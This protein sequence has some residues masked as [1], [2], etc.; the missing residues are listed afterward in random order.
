[1]T[2][3]ERT[4]GDLTIAVVDSHTGGEPTRVIVGGFPELDGTALA[5]KRD[6]L[7][8]N[9]L[10][11]ARLIVDEPRGNEAMVAALLV[12]PQDPRCTAGVIF[13]DRSA[14]LG[15]CGHGT[16]GLVE[17]LRWLGDVETGEVMIETPVG[18]ITA[19]INP[20]GTI[21]IANVPS[22]RIADAITV[23]VP[24]VGSVTGDVAYGGN[25]FFLVRTP[26]FDLTQPIADLLADAAAIEVAVQAAGF[27]DVDHVELFG[28]PTRPDADSR[29][30]VLCPSG[31]YDR[32]PCGTGTSAKLACLAADGRLAEGEV[33]IQESI[34]GSRF[35]ADY[36]WLDSDR[37]EIAP[38]ITGS[39]SITGRGE[40]LIARDEVA[41]GP[42][43]RRSDMNRPQTHDLGSI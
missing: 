39:A 2:Q 16:I 24:G 26:E 33:W 29:S 21:S 18:V 3:R 31:T 7:V 17:T 32:S 36:R 1:V 34:T 40:L 27:P 22:R 42:R 20:D 11:L 13:F 9:H 19:D 12:E 23:E 30:F 5:D 41:S 25:T 8:A 38:R 43:H 28:T 14:V 4:A 15:M 10:T 37:S 6:D 35:S